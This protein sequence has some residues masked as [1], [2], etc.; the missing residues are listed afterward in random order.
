MRKALFILGFVMLT[1]LV[2]ADIL[3]ADES[4][5]S[6]YFAFVVTAKEENQNL[7]KPHISPPKP[8]K[9]IYL[10]V[11]T[12]SGSYGKELIDT[13]IKKGGNAVVIDVEH[14]GGKL[15]FTP[16]NEWVK[17]INPG[18][19]NLDTL[20]ELI[21][22]MHEKGIY[23]IA[24]Q[25][26]FND[27]YTSAIK[28]EWRIKY[29]RG[30]LFDARWLDPSL[31]EVQNYNLYIMQEVAE[32]GF[33]EIQFDYIR[34]PAAS[35]QLLDYHYDEEKFTRV[36]VIND[37]LKKA[38]RVADNYGVQL[39]VDV[40]GAIVWGEVDWKIVGQDAEQMALYADAI[41]PM[42][43]PS[44]VSPGYFGFKNPYGAPYEFVR[45]SIQRFVE[46]AKGNAEIR[47]WVQG[48][49]LRI[50]KFGTWFIKDQVKA[51]FDAG[52]T[53]YTIWSPGNQYQLS[54]PVFSINGPEV[55]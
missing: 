36:D 21:K 32:M 13:L 48:F 55:F 30:S 53:G 41:Y 3:Y 25:V 11:G 5:L 19:T 1:L 28:P 7:K 51:S 18:S 49:P 29:K 9:G 35:H 23:A 37:F 10:T 54:W 46:K 12:M 20:P 40:F 4:R 31:P 50:P 24:R 26:V 27:P 43:Y 22:R 34:F 47:T 17:K 6:R 39:S 8:L 38:R 2:A 33:D 44:H 15:A 14:G 42:T 16:K 45:Q 52:A